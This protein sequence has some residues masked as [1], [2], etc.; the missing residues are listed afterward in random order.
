M[1]DPKVS[2]EAMQNALNNAVYLYKAAT[3]DELVEG[4]LS[5][6]A[7]SILEGKNPEFYSYESLGLRTQFAIAFVVGYSNFG[8]KFL[9]GMFNDKNVTCQAMSGLI[10]LLNPELENTV[11][12]E[13]TKEENTVE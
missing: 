1:E 3:G 5:K 6:D 4:V 13:N 10:S 8:V 2:L 11:D 9:E 12:V 7:A